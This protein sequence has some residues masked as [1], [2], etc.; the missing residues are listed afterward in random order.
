MTRTPI[1]TEVYKG[2]TINIHQDEDVESP[3]ENWDG[4]PDI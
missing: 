2:Y 4:L 3:F 1:H